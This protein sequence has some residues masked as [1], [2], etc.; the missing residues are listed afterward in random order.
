MQVP[1]LMCACTGSFQAGFCA[2]FHCGG[3]CRQLL[4]QCLHVALHI[5]QQATSKFPG[6]VDQTLQVNM[7]SQ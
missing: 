5:H 6:Q 7:V 2:G 4:L 3:D 1:Q